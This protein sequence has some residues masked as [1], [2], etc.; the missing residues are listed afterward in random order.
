ML[1]RL[2]ILAFIC[3]GYGVSLKS[4]KVAFR[5]AL[6]LMGECGVYAKSVGLD[7]YYA[8]SVYLSCF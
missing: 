1:L 4:E 7:Q 8:S 3:M 6:E 5:A 2:W